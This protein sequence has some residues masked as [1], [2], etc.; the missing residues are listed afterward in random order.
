MTCE[1]TNGDG[2]PVLDSAP[3]YTGALGTYTFK[4]KATDA[5]GHEATA[6]HDYKVVDEPTTD[7]VTCTPER[8]PDVGTYYTASVF[9]NCASSAGNSVTVTGVTPAVTGAPAHVPVTAEGTTTLAATSTGGGTASL[10][11]DLDLNDPTI[12]IDT[13]GAAPNNVYLLHGNVPADFSCDDDGSPIVSCVGTVADG[14]PI[15]T[16]SIT[17][18]LKSFTVTATD[19]VGRTKTQT[20]Q[21]EVRYRPSTMPCTKGPGH[22]ISVAVFT[23]QPDPGEPDRTEV[24]RHQLPGV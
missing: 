9:V 4:V 7:T 13:P 17:P 19:S 14:A 11:L 16:S 10:V 8:A 2:Q 15:D 23:G 3:V 1:G 12:D 24:R 6:E 18:P 20:N 5:A 22:Q 21:Y